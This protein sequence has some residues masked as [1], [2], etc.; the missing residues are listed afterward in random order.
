MAPRNLKQMKP[1][2]PHLASR[3]AMGTLDEAYASFANR[4]PGETGRRQPVHTVYG[5]A[6]LFHSRLAARLGEVALK[7]L[8]EYAAD[9]FT[10]ARAIGLPGSERMPKPGKL[11]TASERRFA[12]SPEKLRQEN[13]P[14]WLA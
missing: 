9:A 6:H 8:G 2:P 12:K 5:G 11:S 3:M 7:T 13:R 14:A 10:F 4:Y 1:S